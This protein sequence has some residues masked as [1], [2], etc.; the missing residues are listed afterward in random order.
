MGD[1]LNGSEK[2]INN[3]DEDNAMNKVRRRPHSHQQEGLCYCRVHCANYH[4][5]FHYLQLSCGTGRNWS[6]LTFRFAPL[7]SPPIPATS[8]TQTLCATGPRT[9]LSKNC[10]ETIQL[11]TFIR[12]GI[13]GTITIGS[14][15]SYVI[16]S[17]GNTSDFF[18]DEE[19]ETI[20]Y[21]QYEFTCWTGSKTIIGI[22]NDHLQADCINHSEQINFNNEHWTLDKWFLQENKNITLGQIS[23]LLKNESISFKIEPLQ[24]KSNGTIIKCGMSKV[25][26]DFVSEF[27]LVEVNDK[28][29][30]RNWLE[31]KEDKE[32]NFVLNG[33]RLFDLTR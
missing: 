29:M 18:G 16:K 30:F 26:F 9:D 25:T 31:V 23:S 2:G 14:T 10:M 19:T 7:L 13:F 20:K 15:K 6:G 11:K 21:G 17:L 1:R 33:V 27:R 5:V 12:T 22:Q 24:D 3:E 4:L 8:Q 28:G 32:E